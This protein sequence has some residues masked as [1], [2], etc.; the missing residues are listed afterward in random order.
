MSTSLKLQRGTALGIIALLVLSV[1]FL[2]QEAKSQASASLFISP[3]SGTFSVGS[4]FTVSLFVNT[5]GA[6]VNA[7]EAEL[8]FPPNKLQV[9]SPSAGKSL[10]GIWVTQPAYNN[11]TGSIKFQGAIPPPGINTSQGLVSQITFRATGVGTVVLKFKDASRVLLNDGKGTDILGQT[12]SGVYNL[13]LPPPAGPTVTSQ[14]H[15][16]QEK[17]YQGQSVSFEWGGEEGVQGY[18]YSLSNEPVD[19]PDN[20]S[21][22]VKNNVGYK[23]LAD[24]I[25]YFHVKNLRGGVWGGVT[26]FGVK[27]DST[28]PAEFPIE[29]SPAA[30]TTSL[31]P[32]IN[33]GTTDNLSGI[34]HYE[35]KIVEL[36]PKKTTSGK[37]VVSDQNFFIEVEPLYIA[38]L[39]Y[40]AYD[41]IARAYDNAGNYAQSTKRLE[42][43][44]GIFNIIQGEGLKVRSNFIIPWS[45]M[46]G[47]G[48]LVIIFLGYFV[49]IHR[50]GHRAATAELQANELPY[51]IKKQL[52]EL[53]TLKEKY[54]GGLMMLLLLTATLLSILG[55]THAALAQVE[56]VELSPPVISIYSKNISNEEIFYAGGKTEAVQSEV[57][58]Y[59]QNLSSGETFTQT[60]ASDKKGDWLYSHPTFLSSGTYLVWAQAKLGD[61]MSPPSPQVEIMVS[62]TALQ[63]G[64]SRLSYEIIYLGILIVLSLVIVAMIALGLYH[65]HHGRK[66]RSKLMADV[67][68]AEESLKRGFALLH[69]DIQS[70]LA[71]IQRAKLSK[72]LSRE[73]KILEEKILRDLQTVKNY[74][75][76]EIWEVEKEI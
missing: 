30:V 44:T 70:E 32:T 31:K 39:D 71:L 46:W 50:R 45:W 28:P 26:H 47:I 57:L 15:P 17:W 11:R 36:S 37:E 14:T 9:A 6:E 41:V 52:E 34:S 67:R 56:R 5:G 51:E 53:K 25:H 74:I 43:K 35:L 33:F 23:N 68:K 20:I 62:P 54:K 2:F 73:E 59:L 21:E 42:I 61:V 24:G 19:S 12:T 10:V 60:I 29:I 4:T 13:A 66:K 69:R 22:G 1:F 76:K 58:V 49:G 48:A 55:G 3:A 63:I 27:I 8:E 18:S 64:A 16:D 75:G 38:E 72:E 65:R 40:G 7:I